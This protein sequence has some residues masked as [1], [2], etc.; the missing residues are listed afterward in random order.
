MDRI[1]VENSSQISGIAFDSAA[2]EAEESGQKVGVLEIEFKSSGAVYQYKDVP[3]SV[4]NAMLM[5][6]SVGK[7]FY[8]NIKGKFEYVKVEASN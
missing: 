4:Y 3:V 7:Y 1:K 8:A 2:P 6:E 5:A